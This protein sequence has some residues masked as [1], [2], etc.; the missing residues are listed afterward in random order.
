MPG[1]SRNQLGPV[2]RAGEDIA[3]E[4][5]KKNGYTIIGRNVKIGR[6]DIDIICSDEKHVVFVE[7]K[8][9]SYNPS[10]KNTLYGSPSAAVTYKKKKNILSAAYTWLRENRTGLYPRID[11]IEVILERTDSGFRLNKINHFRNAV[12][13]DR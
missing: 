5:L 13:N 9:R 4:Y 12:T 3:A 8:A 7:V 2:G 6:T 10:L 1:I 11:V